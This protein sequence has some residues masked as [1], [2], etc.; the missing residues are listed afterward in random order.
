MQP[1]FVGYAAV[2]HVPNS[3]GDLIRPHAFKMLRPVVPL[4]WC[5]DPDLCLGLAH[6]SLD[7]RGL[8]VV[9]RFNQDDR[10]G[11]LL[12]DRIDGA[13][14]Y[15]MLKAGA[16]SGL[17]VGYRSWN[18]QQRAPFGRLILDAE[19]YEVSLVRNPAAD[20]AGVTSVQ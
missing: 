7:V 18:Y 14:A 8:R 17:S 6:L 4:L 9:G 10:K 1:G 2:F 19:V 5:H 3:V 20:G 15:T 11:F 12:T 16:I 13:A